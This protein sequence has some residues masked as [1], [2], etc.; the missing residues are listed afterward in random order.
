MI[1]R[2][3]SIDIRFHSMIIR[4]HSTIVK[5]F[6]CTENILYKRAFH[7]VVVVHPQPKIEFADLPD[8]DFPI[9]SL[10]TNWL[11]CLTG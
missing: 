11:I 9:N 1:I 3:H 5:I 8:F 10:N 6:P 2:F 7:L 4:L